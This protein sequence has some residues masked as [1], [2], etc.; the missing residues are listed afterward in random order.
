M[1]CSLQEIFDRHFESYAQDR[2][3]HPRERRAAWCIQHC[4]RAEMGSHVLACPAGHYSHVQYH[5]CRHRSCPRCA[6]QARQQWLSAQLPRLLPCPHFHV[7]FTLPHELIAL[8]QFNRSWFNQLL[9]DCARESLLALCADPRHL[10]AT[11]GLLMALHTWGRTLSRHPH[12]HCLVSAG[13]L[14]AQQQWRASRP[15][16]LVPVQALQC[17]FRGKMLS[18]LQQAFRTQHLHLP[19]SHDAT[20]WQ[21]VLRTLWR[22]HW[23]VQISEP[24]AHGRGVAQYLARYVKGG[25]LGSRNTFDLAGSTV[26]L[27]YIDHRDGQH[28]TLTLQA[29]E[30]ISRVL[31]HAPPRGQHTVRQAGLY[32]TALR[33]RHAR[34]RALLTPA[35]PPL[36]SSPLACHD[37]QAPTSP[38][39]CPTCRLPL[40]RQ[41]V[42]PRA[43]H[44]GEVSKP[45]L[46]PPAR[47]C[48]TFRSSGRPRA[49]PSAAA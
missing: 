6:A 22:S 27:P 16:F 26:R 46:P 10:G 24:Y 42:V 23:N 37:L 5:A 34:C 25:P 9:F 49:S 35:A 14:D 1:H 17:L 21:Q 44:R 8:W 47:L 28:K 7:V 12:V 32:A 41:F 3:L 43:H 33:A 4:H 13:G 11:P 29:P 38:P 19:P 40:L 18:H 45:H 48:P 20:H 36:P 31:C 15:G 39:A 2:S 30:F